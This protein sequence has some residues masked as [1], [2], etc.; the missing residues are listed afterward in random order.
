MTSER[1]HE[2][3][4]PNPFL[5]LVGLWQNYLMEWIQVSRNFLVAAAQLSVSAPLV[6][7]ALAAQALLALSV[8]LALADPATAVRLLVG[9]SSIPLVVLALAVVALV[10]G[11]PEKIQ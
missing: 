9:R 10:R 1:E 5:N 2:G 11:A 8:E 7:V 6:L 4:V 3:N